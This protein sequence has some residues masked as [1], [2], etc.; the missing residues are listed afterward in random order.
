MKTF[1]FRVQLQRL[2]FTDFGPALV[3]LI[4]V[5][6]EMITR[7]EAE[8]PPWESDISVMELVMAKI[9]AEDLLCRYHRRLG[10]L[11]N[12]LIDLWEDSSLPTVQQFALALRN[13]T[14]KPV[15]EQRV[16][17]GEGVES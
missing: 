4:A 16:F 15:F 14:F 17:V 2:T 8:P 3:Y 12:H 10:H 1:E 7:L 5:M 13:R 11:E 6:A 9:V